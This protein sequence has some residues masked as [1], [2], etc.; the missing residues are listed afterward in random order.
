[1]QLSPSIFWLLFLICTTLCFHESLKESPFLS[2]SFPVSSFLRW[3]T[4]SCR[5][6][7]SMHPNTR[8]FCGLHLLKKTLQ[9]GLGSSAALVLGLDHHPGISHVSSPDR[10]PGFANL[11]PSPAWFRAFL[12]LFSSLLIKDKGGAWYEWT[13]ISSYFIDGLCVTF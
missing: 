2:A 6:L 12:S 3:V 5:N 4:T 8:W 7:F 1:M 9:A 13:C 10:T 11:L